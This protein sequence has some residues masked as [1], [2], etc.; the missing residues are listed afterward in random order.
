V[1]FDILP[2]CTGEMQ[3]FKI[4]VSFVTTNPKGCFAKSLLHVENSLNKKRA[5]LG[6]ALLLV[7]GDLS[8]QF[9][10][11]QLLETR[12]WLGTDERKSVDKE[13]GCGLH[14]QPE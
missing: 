12:Q 8:G 7:L 11:D 4:H 1:T 13:R 3:C 5:G 14:T 9:Q 6:P 2:L 10:I